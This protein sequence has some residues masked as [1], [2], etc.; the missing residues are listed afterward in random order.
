MWRTALAAVLV[1]FFD[2]TLSAQSDGAKL[3]E[4]TPYSPAQKK[5]LENPNDAQAISTYLNEVMMVVLRTM[6]S[7]PKSAR[8]KLD[9]MEEFAAKLKA[10]DPAAKSRLATLKA[11]AEN[12]R[13]RIAVQNMSLADVK[14]KV[15]D[16]PNDAQAISGYITKLQSE[17]AP[18]A[19]KQP[20]EAAKLLEAAKAV[21]AK[22][23]DSAT[24]DAAR[25]QI[26][27]TGSTLLAIERSIETGRLSLA[28][29][30]QKLIDNPDNMLALT[31]FYSKLSIEVGPLLRSKPA[32]AAE[33]VEQAKAILQKVE[34]TATTANMKTQLANYRRTIDSM[35]RTIEAGKKLIEM[36][37]K[38][39]AP[40]N[41]ESWVNGPALTDANL[42][43]KV[44][45]LDFWA[46]WCGPCIATFPHLREWNEKYADKGLV[47]IGLT[48]YY[49]YQWDEAA[50]RATR[51]TEKVSHE[52][53]QA[54]LAKFA[55]SHELKHRFA[56]QADGSLSDY[57][58]VT[59]IPHVV[60]IDQQGKI[61]L[62]KVGSDEA[63][64][65]EI[66]EM[67]AQLLEPKPAGGE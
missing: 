60:V 28:E 49:N 58:G 2:V 9:A 65:K 50:K 11:V 48:Q 54:M 16:N 12:Y 62:M 34:E 17:L 51:A 55:E 15:L 13:S 5:L 37:G 52:E 18:L 41:I 7:D 57:Y 24:T 23:R 43:G 33:K 19:T 40:L 3:G 21:L 25:R 42:K 26:A 6:Q 56:I 1:L 59:G 29:L 8:E 64:A 35:T 46:V 32:E 20:D 66:G 44:V 47:M 38:D 36:I 30:G 45:F 14:K 63:N 27:A 67:L 4:A 53:E 22:V 61:R 31:N 39:A 10:D